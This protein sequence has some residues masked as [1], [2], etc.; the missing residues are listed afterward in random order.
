MPMAWIEA[1]SWSSITFGVVVLRGLF[2]SVIRLRGSPLR[3]SAMMG[4]IG[5][6]LCP[7]YSTGR[8]LSGCIP[9]GREIAKPAEPGCRALARRTPAA[10]AGDAARAL[11]GPS[12]EFR[13]RTLNTARSHPALATTRYAVKFRFLRSSTGRACPHLSYLHQDLRIMKRVIVTSAPLSIA[14]ARKHSMLD[15]LILP[16]FG[17]GGS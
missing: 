11:L 14:T 13:C 6:A 9:A 7:F 1:T 15:N 2:G 4:S 8:P 5:V 10:V 16:T 17:P 3:S 12:C